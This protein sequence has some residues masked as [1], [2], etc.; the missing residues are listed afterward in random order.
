MQVLSFILAF[1]VAQ[2]APV[3]ARPPADTGLFPPREELIRLYTD[4]DES[5]WPWGLDETF[6]S[7]TPE[8]LTVGVIR[9]RTLEERWRAYFASRAGD[10]IPATGTEAWVYPLTQRG[11]LVDNYLQPRVGGP[12]DA[13]DIFVPREGAPV[14]S[15][16]AGVVI[17]AADGWRGGWKRRA[18]LHYEGDGLSRRAGNGVMLFEPSS[19]GYLY[20][21]HLQGGSVAVRSGDI[22]R[23]G[24]VV[25]KVGHTGNASEPGHG[26]HL[27]FAW[28][29]PGSGCGVDGVLVSENPIRSVRAARARLKAPAR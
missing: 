8:E 12:H 5:R 27:H 17:A 1:Q 3:P 9:R 2:A 15:P 29:R 6:V 4:C 26:R 25:G 14:R 21:I 23:A 28:K 20:L 19:G 16:V 24:Q 7:K 18:G 11:R 10:S 13:L 22:V